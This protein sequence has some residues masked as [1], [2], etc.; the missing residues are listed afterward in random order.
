MSYSR[1][2]RRSTAKIAPTSRLRPRRQLE[3]VEDE[4]TGAQAPQDVIELLGL[5]QRIARFGLRRLEGREDGAVEIQQAGALARL[6]DPNLSGLRPWRGS[7]L[8]M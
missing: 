6:H 3:L 1:P 8:D 4:N 7:P 5:A 2:R